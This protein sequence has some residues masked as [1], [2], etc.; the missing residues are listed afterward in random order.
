MQL[1]HVGYFGKI[2]KKMLLSE[3]QTDVRFNP[4]L[5][6]VKCSSPKFLR[7]DFNSNF[8]YLLL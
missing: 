4:Q 8:V 5:N 3:F 7:C 2:E 6:K 1:K